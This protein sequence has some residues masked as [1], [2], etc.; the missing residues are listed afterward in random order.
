[1][2]S[3][4]R[5]GSPSRSPRRVG[6]SGVFC[7][8]GFLLKGRWEENPPWNCEKENH[9]ILWKEGKEGMWSSSCCWSWLTRGQ[10]RGFFVSLLKHRTSGIGHI[11]TPKHIGATTIVKLKKKQK[12]LGHIIMETFFFSFE[13]FLLFFLLPAS[14]SN[15]WWHLEKNKLNNRY[16]FVQTNQTQHLFFSFVLIFFVFAT[17]T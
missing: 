1:M 5:L 6:E 16:Q 2:K 8:F 11:E 12:K 7:L 3:D 9:G 10:E 17:V 13:V 4:E 14:W 15:I